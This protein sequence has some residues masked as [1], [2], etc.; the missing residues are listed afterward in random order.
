MRVIHLSCVAPPETGGIG[1]VAFDEVARLAERG[2]DAMLIAPIAKD[3]PAAP[4]VR[5][6]PASWRFGN[7]VVLRRPDLRSV[8]RD[9]DVVHLHY[10]FFGTAG[11][12]AALRRHGDV[13]RLV[14]TLHM[15]ASA[16]GFKGLAFAAHRLLFQRRILAT[17][18]RLLVSSMDYAAHSSFAGDVTRRATATVELP[19]S[20]DHRFFVPGPSDRAAFG[21]PDDAQVVG[22][23]GGMDRA[24]AFKGVDVLLRAL[25]RLPASTW[26]VFIGEGSLRRGYERLAERLGLSARVRFLGRVADPAMPAAIRT[27]DVLA[28]PSVSGAEAFGLVALEAQACGVPVVASDLP[29][30]RTV[31]ERG[32]TGLLVP[33]RDVAALADALRRILRDPAERLRMGR[34][35]RMRVEERYTPDRHVGRLLE[36]YQDVCASPS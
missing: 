27:F 20:V 29:G 21:I 33:P 1:S 10:P 7:A 31:V 36:I 28:F 34:G 2:V 15:D 24:H 13:R 8:L 3:V 17:A 11:F 26:G 12:V 25:A 5:R 32:R 30:V 4:R 19:F 22:F 16:P 14:M 6:M 35:A 18:D 23:I 9:A